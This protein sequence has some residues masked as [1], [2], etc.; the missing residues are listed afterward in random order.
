MTLRHD[1]LLSSDPCGRVVGVTPGSG[2]FE[3]P[4]P[5]GSLAMT[6]SVAP[7]LRFSHEPLSDAL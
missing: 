7:G 2:W 1:G 5:R 6:A 4:E 3:L